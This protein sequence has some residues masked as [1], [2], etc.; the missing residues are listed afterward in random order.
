MLKV[1]N[2]FSLYWKLHPQYVAYLT[3]IQLPI[4]I[5]EYSLYILVTKILCSLSAQHLHPFFLCTWKLSHQNFPFFLSLFIH[6][7][8]KDTLRVTVHQR[9]DVGSG[10]QSVSFFA[11]V[12]LK[13]RHTLLSSQRVRPPHVGVWHSW[14]DTRQSAESWIT[15]LRFHHSLPRHCQVE[16]PMQRWHQRKPWVAVRH[17]H[18]PG[19]QILGIKGTS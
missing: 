19:R 12:T 18:W 8:K 3:I 13:F 15:N 6:S 14:Q 4:L 1:F 11:P 7:F 2:R 5:S 9:R 16:C 10:Q 17:G